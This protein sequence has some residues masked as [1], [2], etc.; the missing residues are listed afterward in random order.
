MIIALCGKKACGKDTIAS[1]ITKKT[2]FVTLAFATPLKEM[3][4]KVF[5]I[6]LITFN[7]PVLKETLFERPLQMDILYALRISD[8]IN[9]LG[10][11]LTADQYDRICS[12]M[13]GK[14]F[15]KPRDILQFIA[16]DIIRNH[17][18]STFWV[19]LTVKE[20]AKYP[21]VIITDCRLT[22]ERSA[23]KDLK[24]ILC[25][26]KRD[27]GYC[28]SHISE[29]DM[30]SENEYNVIINN[31]GSLIQLENDVGL[32]LTYKGVRK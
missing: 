9:E 19:D 1:F 11:N 30:G 25:L 13:S 17:V 29:N 6:P 10:Y 5:N 32:W 20:I 2:N 15:F 21:N 22:N 3:V 14:V 4:S 31:D 16:T 28:D 12:L 26:V 24:A 27:T 18:S 8:Y 7:D 23:L